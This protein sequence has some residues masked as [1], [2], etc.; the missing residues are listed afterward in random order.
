MSFVHLL[1]EVKNKKTTGKYFIHLF[2]IVAILFIPATSCFAPKR[3]QH[4]EIYLYIFLLCF[5][6]LL[7]LRGTNRAY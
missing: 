4:A 7:Q 2:R 6:H 1:S 3:L 5:S